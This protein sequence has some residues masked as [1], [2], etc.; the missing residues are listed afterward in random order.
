MSNDPDNLIKEPSSP[1]ASRTYREVWL[2]NLFSNVG[3]LVQLV[4]ASWLMTTL[5][6]SEQMVALVQAST[7]LPMMLVA[8]FSG[9]IADRFNRRS[10]L[11]VSQSFTM[12]ASIGL[13]FFVWEGWLDAWLLLAFTFLIGCGTALKTPAWQASV[14]DMVNRAT[15]PSAIALN[16][17]GYNIARSAG[18]AL[19]GVVVAV[20]GPAAAFVAN[21]LSNVGMLAALLRWRGRQPTSQ[22]PPEPFLSAVTA[23]FRY[24]AMAPSIRAVL[25]RVTMFGFATAGVQA[26]LPLIARDQMRGG[27]LTYGL[28]LGAFGAGAVLGGLLIGRARS[29]FAPEA[30]FRLSSS[31]FAAGTLCVALSAYFALTL[32]ALAFLGGAWVIVLSTMNVSV[33]LN[34][35]NWVL[36]R[37]LALY[38]T[39]AFGGIA[40]G[41]WTS[42]WLAG[43]FGVTEAL[44][45]SFALQILVVMLTIK[46]R[47]PPSEGV[48]L[49]PFPWNGGL[50]PPGIRPQTGP[51]VMTAEFRIAKN[52]TAAFLTLMAERRRIRYRNGARG[53]ELVR[54]I[55][56]PELWVERY[57]V[58]SWS[59]YLRHRER[60]LVHEAEVFKRIREL[61]KGAE[62]PLIRRF[63]TPQAGAQTMVFGTPMDIS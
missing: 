19:G 41:S 28:L 56:D 3:T 37:V 27:A 1:F 30:L 42:G 29:R 6:S 60:L 53:W 46:F 18:P 13:A 51:I 25:P 55:S 50:D 23:G 24:V 11:L 12:L 8:V 33:Q 16:A 17:V 34:S 58:L 54:D 36:A 21:A 26:L 38:Q 39:A 61:H 57:R 22:L 45:I 43:R 10:V 52:D 15:L 44:L 31:I 4:G 5:T 47:L 63:E 40:L 49:T 7:A 48:N 20:A 14:G 59:E 62:P 35:P 32:A 9:A 2:G